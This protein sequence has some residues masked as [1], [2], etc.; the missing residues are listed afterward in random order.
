MECQGGSPPVNASSLGKFSLEKD[1]GKELRW[2]EPPA[3]GESVGPG[4]AA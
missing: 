3:R 4:E 2:T 1:V